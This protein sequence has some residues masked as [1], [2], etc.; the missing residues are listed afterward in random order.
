MRIL[1]IG[2]TSGRLDCIAESVVKNPETQLFIL[3]N[4]SNVGLIQKGLVTC[5]PT[6]DP[7]FVAH[8]ADLLHTRDTIAIISNEE[9]LGNG[10]VDRLLQMNIPT[11]GPTQKLARIETS[12]LYTRMLMESFSGINPEWCDFHPGATLLEMSEWM[13]HLDDDFVVKPDGLTGGKGVR[14]MGD[15]FNSR[16]EGLKY[17]QQLLD[18][19]N[20]IIIEEKLVGEE[21]SLMSL[22]GGEVVHTY[23]IQDF[24]RLKNGD[25]G[26]NTGGMGSYACSTIGETSLPFAQNYYEEACKTNYLASIELQVDNEQEYRGILYGNYIITQNRLRLIE[27]NARFG[28]PEV[29]NLL[30]L[31]ETDGAELFAAIATGKLTANMVKFTNKA[32]VVKYL[33]PE[34]Y[35]ET[36]PTT[37]LDLSQV[38]EQPGLRVYRSGLNLDVTTGSRI[39]A[40]VGIADTLEEAEQIAEIACQE[41]P[42]PVIHRS[43]IGTEALIIHRS[44][45]DHM[46]S[47]VDLG[48]AWRSPQLRA[49]FETEY[50]ISPISSDPEEYLDQ[51]RTGHI[52]DYHEGFIQWAT[53]H[54]SP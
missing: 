9:P 17:C 28:D 41:V 49:Q 10:V 7:E 34:T 30:P 31:L 16:D 47:R 43:D 33:V 52:Q 2:N 27:F 20:S 18:S 23:P 21:F 45:K 46:T 37:Q 6:A 14:V 4:Y 53:A 3:T 50:Q 19:G 40:M 42:G 32:S 11:V 51:T 54:L 38:T 29:M 26:P 48:N 13:Q 25:T 24:K 44:R 36:G 8:W 35:P 15:H 5:G 12:K 1:L 39:V 22:I